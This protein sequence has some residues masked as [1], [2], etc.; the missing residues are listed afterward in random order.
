LK[1]SMLVI[2][3]IIF[4]TG[5]ITIIHLTTTTMDFSR[6]N[7]YWNG[8]SIFFEKAKSY[9]VKEIS[10]IGNI[11]GLKNSS[12]LIISPLQDFSD[13]DA[14]SIR[15]FLQNGNSLFLIDD[16]GTGNNLLKLLNSHIKISSFALAG[17][18]RDYKDP[19][20][21]IAYSLNKSRITNGID[22]ISFDRPSYVNG[23]EALIDTSLLSWPE[24]ANSSVNTRVG[25]IGRY[26]LFA[27]ESYGNGEIFVLA[28]P[29]I[30]INSMQNTISGSPGITL[31]TNILTYRD[32][33]LILMSNSRLSQA[34]EFI[35]VIEQIKQVDI[36]KSILII[37]ISIICLLFVR[38]KFED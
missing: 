31:I 4:L 13:N 26:N 38:Y 36:Y 28:D 29:S 30:F 33:T 7:P 37:L 34:N 21:L 12:L 11:E 16:F 19:A 3:I 22:K 17:V 27:K 18:D 5:S 6:Y 8:T 15:K 2:L 10:S 25:P 9:H 32:T 35:P 14:T 20:S 24:P 1:I 23:G